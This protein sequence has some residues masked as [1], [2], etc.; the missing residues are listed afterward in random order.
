MAGQPFLNNGLTATPALI[1]LGHHEGKPPIPLNRP[2]VLIG[3]RQNAHIHLVSRSISKAHA[4]LIQSDGRVYIHDLASR[5]KVIING[6]EVKQA[7][8]NVGDKIQVGSFTFEF[9]SPE[10]GRRP[11]SA[12]RRRRSW[13]WRGSLSRCG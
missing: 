2:V 12:V 10:A 4:L 11:Q 1:P 8:L 6:R 7:T 13:R 3:A 9:T 5:T